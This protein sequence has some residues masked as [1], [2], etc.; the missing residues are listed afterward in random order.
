MEHDLITG[1]QTPLDYYS[2]TYS[3]AS[4]HGNLTHHIIMYQKNGMLAIAGHDRGRLN[5]GDWP[6]LFG[7][8]CLR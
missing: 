7:G 6:L 2:L 5:D 3:F 8:Q 4:L 1:I